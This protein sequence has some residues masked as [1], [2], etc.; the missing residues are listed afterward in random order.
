VLAALDGGIP[1]QPRHLG[2]LM[3]GDVVA[4]QPGQAAVA[5]GIGHALDAVR[6]IALASGAD[7][8]I[9]QGS[10]AAFHPGRTA[11]LRVAGQTV[12]HAGELLP[13][14]AEE[15]DLPR[16][17]AVVEL[18]LDAVIALAEPGVE[19][20]PIGTLPAATQDLSL[21]V[22]ADVPAAAVAAAVREG[23][24][25]LLEHLRLVDDYRGQGVADG[26]KSLT[27]ALRFRAADRTLT[28][29][30]AS[31]AKLAGAALAAERTGASIRE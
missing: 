19:A 5:A 1:A 13:A 11:E 18:D 20:R 22:A 31:E 28:A 2:V 16:T 30:E 17:V 12:G 10:H 6:E 4:K 8:E 9:V 26:S 23:A 3:L 24:G 27:F 29:A 21:I 14:I 7:I 15:A 25:E